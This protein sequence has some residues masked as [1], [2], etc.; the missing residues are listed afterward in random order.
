MLSTHKRFLSKQHLRKPN[1]FD[2]VFKRGKRLLDVCLA[3][4]YVPNAQGYS[5]L[6]M[7]VSKRNCALAVNRNRLKRLIR[8]AFRLNQSDLSAL[9][10]V[11]SLR[12]PL[13]ISDEEL[14]ACIEKLFIQLKTQCNGSVSN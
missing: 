2:T 8:E 3:F 14:Q 13:K 10:L 9:D 5:R 1:E 6:G 12:S 11:V 4:Y 7:V